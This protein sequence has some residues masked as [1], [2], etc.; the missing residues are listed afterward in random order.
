MNWNIC[1]LRYCFEF[2]AESLASAECYSPAPLDLAGIAFVESL[3]SGRLVATDSFA[4]G[5][6]SLGLADPDWSASL[7][8]P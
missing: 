6:A 2:V 1:C 4:F 3:E 5:P 8:A 7:L